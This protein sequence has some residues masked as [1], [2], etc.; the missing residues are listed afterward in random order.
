LLS[1]RVKTGETLQSF[2]S[3]L[4]FNTCFRHF[5]LDA[6]SAIDTNKGLGEFSFG[7]SNLLTLL[8][9]AQEINKL[10]WTMDSTVLASISV[11]LGPVTFGKL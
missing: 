2:A 8:I 5:H 9:F 11:W 10:F 6:L 3:F 7:L 1:L 4:S